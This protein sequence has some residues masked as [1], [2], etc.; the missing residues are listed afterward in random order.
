ML[1]IYWW[2]D[3][4]KI[5]LLFDA[6]FIN[7]Q[8]WFTINL[9]LSRLESACPHNRIEDNENIFSLINNFMAATL[10][11]DS[12][13]HVEDLLESQQHVVHRI[14]WILTAYCVGWWS[15]IISTR[16]DSTCE[17]PLDSKEGKKI[18]FFL[19][20][21]AF[22]SIFWQFS[23]N[24]PLQPEPIGWERESKILFYCCWITGLFNLWP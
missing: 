3:A 20:R 10:A 8:H 12:E 18:E 17:M 19:L 11:C 5:E 7:L 23:G 13:L 15:N 1:C 16:L 2:M 21:F 22:R 24:C 9:I 14:H 4:I 6:W